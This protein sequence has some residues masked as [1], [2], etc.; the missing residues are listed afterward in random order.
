MDVKYS[1]IIPI[2]NAETYLDECLRSL[3]EQIYENFEVILVD[4]G[5]NDNSCEIYSKYEKEDQRFKVYKKKNGGVSSARNL[6]LLKACG[7]YVLFV[8]ADD[9]CDK[10]MLKIIG[11]NIKDNIDIISFGYY[12][13]YKNTI[14][15]IKPSFKE[16]ISDYEL[17]FY[18]GEE[19][20]GY[21]WNKVFLNEIIKSN[22]IKFN[23]DIHYSEDLIFVTDY[24]KYV[25]NFL[26]IED[27]LY[28][29]RMRKNSATFNFYNEKSVTS[30]EAFNYLYNKS[31]NQI[32]KEIIEFKYLKNYYRLKKIINKNN[33]YKI[34]E[35]FL[36]NEKKIISRLSLKDKITY[37]IIKYLNPI[38][39]LTKKLKEIKYKLYN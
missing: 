8:D 18:E 20:L 24:F 9:Y 29:Y 6:G 27:C 37:G 28:F 17:G 10:K 2:Y 4:D 38:Y 36:L 23:T 26:I 21:L 3:K 32:I 30:L 31:D 16:T 22:K 39:I 12:K 11:E 34:R 15:D 35:D 5:S 19:I 14:C 1:I 25:N 7:K 13:K 33:N